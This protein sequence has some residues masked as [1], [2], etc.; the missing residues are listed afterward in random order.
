MNYGDICLV[1]YPFTDNSGSKVRPVLI[2]SKNQYNHGDDRVVIPVSSAPEPGDPHVVFMSAESTH[3]R[4]S[5]LR[6]D[7]AFKFAKP[8]TVARSLFRRRIGALDAGI[9]SEVQA[10]LAGMFV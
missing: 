6:T 7:S 9:L 5:G 1:E 3:F 2:V 4:Q 10:K 8:L